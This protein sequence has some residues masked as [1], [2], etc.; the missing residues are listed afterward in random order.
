MWALE[1]RAVLVHLVLDFVGVGHGLTD[2]VVAHE[3]ALLGVG[4]GEVCLCGPGTK[5]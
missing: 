2:L 4:G 3:T 5:T 1:G